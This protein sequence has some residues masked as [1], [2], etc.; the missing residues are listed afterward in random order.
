[1]RTTLLAAICAAFLTAL[2]AV[3]QEAKPDPIQVM[4]L[5]TFHFD[6]PGLDY[7]NAQVDDMLTPAR[8]A[9]IAHVTEALSRFRPTKVGVE[10]KPGAADAD[11]ERYKA[12]TLPPTR[13]EIV[14]IGFRIAKANG[15]PVV[16][17][18]DTPMSLPFDDTLAFA[19]THDRQDIIDHIGVVS[20]A[21]VAA[22]E[23]TLRDKG[24]AATFR[25]L[26]DSASAL[27]SHGLYRELLMLGAGDQ[28]PGLETVL[29]W[30]K[31]NLGICAHLLQ[32]A[33][34]GDRVLVMFG[35]GHL[36]LLQ[37]CVRETPGYVLVDALDYLPND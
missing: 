28:Q 20:D 8:Q 23:A 11:Y 1:M 33:Q 21:N 26:N 24:V 18:L 19:Q 30:Y 5:G 7:R 27:A 14:Q 16:Y 2:P 3:A 13:D 34:P 29:A 15:L 32:T 31:R 36:P 9:E 10:W 12:G 37:Q 25:L 4:V 6:N 17:G 35:A 22:Q